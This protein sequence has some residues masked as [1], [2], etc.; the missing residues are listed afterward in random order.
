MSPRQID[1][2]IARLLEPAAREPVVPETSAAVTTLSPRER[3][4]LN[5]LAEGMTNPEIAETLFISTRTA[6]NHVSNILARLDLGSRTSAVAYA[7]R[8]DLA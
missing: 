6:A 1:A 3:E 4:V 7:I 8:H 2:E 5:L